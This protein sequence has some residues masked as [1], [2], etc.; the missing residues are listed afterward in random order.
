MSAALIIIYITKFILPARFG[1]YDLV[2]AICDAE[3]AKSTTV[4][5]S[6]TK[7]WHRMWWWTLLLLLLL[8]LNLLLAGHRHHT[9]GS[10]DFC[11]HRKQFLPFM[12]SLYNVQER[13]T[14]RQ[15]CIY[16]RAKGARA[17]GGKF[18]GAAY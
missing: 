10:V 5:V 3:W 17:Q 18:P 15:G 6:I 9:Y 14:H 1:P 4:V 2:T 16:A 13:N 11:K 12:H 8:L 7:F